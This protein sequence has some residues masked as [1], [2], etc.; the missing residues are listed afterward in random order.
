MTPTARCHQGS[1]SV[2]YHHEEKV[3]Q[4]GVHE[5]QRNH[6]YHRNLPVAPILSAKKSSS[7]EQGIV[8]FLFPSVMR[9]HARMN[10][11]NDVPNDR[12]STIVTHNRTTLTITDLGSQQHLHLFQ[13]L[14][15]RTHVTAAAIGFVCPLQSCCASSSRSLQDNQPQ[16]LSVNRF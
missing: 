2:H 6:I 1:K 14:V 10:Q 13:H 8:W 3:F 11:I 12:P 9:G 5:N 4:A 7:L 16:Q 15:A